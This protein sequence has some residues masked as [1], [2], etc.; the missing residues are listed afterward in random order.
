MEAAGQLDSPAAGR[1]LRQE[2]AGQV[3]PVE[4]AREAGQPA[5]VWMGM[6]SMT[7]TLTGFP[8]VEAHR[9]IPAAA[10]RLIA[11]GPPGWW[12]TGA[13]PGRVQCRGSL[14]LKA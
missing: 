12:I 8:S 6:N 5:V 14:F 13:R 11:A 10:P 7:I 4:V 2:I 1:S 9:Y 3:L